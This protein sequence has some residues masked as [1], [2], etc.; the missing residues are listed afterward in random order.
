MSPWMCF[1]THETLSKIWYIPIEVY[2]Y[3]CIYCIKKKLCPPDQRQCPSPK[4][5]SFM[6]YWYVFTTPL[7]KVHCT[8]GCSIMDIICHYTYTTEQPRKIWLVFLALQI[9]H[10]C[11]FILWNCPKQ[12]RG[13][14]G[15]Q[16]WQNSWLSLTMN[17]VSNSSCCLLYIQ[18]SQ[19]TWLL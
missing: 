2:I 10:L 7:D 4:H 13:H 12:W 14:S 9:T 17:R 5:K 11:V 1:F 19:M 6:S 8:R 18:V 3:T 15:L 16:V